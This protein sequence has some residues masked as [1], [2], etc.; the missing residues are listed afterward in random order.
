MVG[1]VSTTALID[2]GAEVTCQSEEVGTLTE[3]KELE[4]SEVARYREVAEVRDKKY[5]EK[6]DLEET[7]EV[8]DEEIKEKAEQSM[9]DSPIEK[10]LRSIIWALQKFRTY[11]KGARIIKPTDHM[12]LTFLKTC[13]FVKARLELWILA[14]QDYNIEVEYCPGRENVEADMLRRLYPEKDWKKR[15]RKTG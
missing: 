3:E 7:I 4:I 13:E 11:L 9:R 5:D 10:E 2:T 6:E 8:S 12:V 15:K 14:I 1:G